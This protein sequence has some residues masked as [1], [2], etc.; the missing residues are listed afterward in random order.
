MLLIQKGWHKFVERKSLHVHDTVEFRWNCEI[1]TIL[2]KTQG[3]DPAPLVDAGG[4][5]KYSS[6]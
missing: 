6:L 4:D 3:R 2:F 5:T 1:T